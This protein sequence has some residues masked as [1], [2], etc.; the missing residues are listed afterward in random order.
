MNDKSMIREIFQAGLDKA[1][2][3]NFIPESVIFKN[4]ILTIDNQSFDL[5]N[6]KN[7]YVYGSGKASIEMVKALPLAL[8]EKI[9]DSFVVCNYHEN[10]ENIKVFESTHPLPSLKS[11]ESAEKLLKSFKDMAHDDFYIYLLSGGSSAMIEKPID[12][13]SLEEVRHFTEVLLQKSVPIDEINIVRKELS[14]IKGG[15]LLANTKANGVVLV[16]SDVI[17]DDLQSIGS[18]PLIQNRSS[19]ENFY[20][21]LK[22]YNLFSLISSK[23][24]YIISREYITKN[25]PHFI[26][27]NNSKSLKSSQ[28]KAEKLGFKTDIVTNSLHGDVKVVA[29]DI[30][31]AIEKYRIVSTAPFCLIFGGESTVEVRENGKGGRNQELCLWFLKELQK[32]DNITFLSGA[33][34][35]IDGNSIA[36]GGVVDIS[37]R[38]ED[39]DLYLNNN[40]SFHFLQREKSL[41]MYGFSGTNVMDIMI[42]L[43]R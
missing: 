19:H 34:D 20:K 32:G 2:P 9:S 39:I 29:K 23:I 14:I 42:V 8:K 24:E 36:A 25:I 41:I 26:L 13:F 1:L 21:V 18:A 11:I 10:I 38:V 37:N 15:G 28:K 4:S 35:G 43:V 3:K 12:G 17:G 7:I 16:L 33:T 22:K 6:Y 40:D 5:K 27:M 31:Q 30:Y